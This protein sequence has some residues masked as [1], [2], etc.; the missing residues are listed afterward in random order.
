MCSF[1]KQT[2]LEWFC[3]AP[4]SS[5]HISSLSL[6]CQVSLV[7][8]APFAEE[9]TE[10]EWLSGPPVQEIRAGIW[11]LGLMLSLP[12]HTGIKIR[13][14]DYQY[15]FFLSEF[16]FYLPILGIIG[17]FWR[18]CWQHIWEWGPG[19]WFWCSP[20]NALLSSSGWHGSIPDPEPLS[21]LWDPPGH[22]DLEEGGWEGEG[23]PDE[24]EGGAQV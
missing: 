24:G 18:E 16:L 9:E 19:R 13:E 23:P 17:N 2:L 5:V 11:T 6:S 12:Y 22:K 8:L 21:Q 7:K 14:G 1:K 10:S 15:C 3:F 20:L 4:C